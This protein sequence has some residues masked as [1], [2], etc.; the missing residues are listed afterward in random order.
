MNNDGNL[1]L[2]RN[3]ISALDI[4]TSKVVEE[5]GLIEKKYAKLK[6]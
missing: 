4:S 6:E 3:N 1:S 2:S 5:K